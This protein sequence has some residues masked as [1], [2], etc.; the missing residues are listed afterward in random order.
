MAKGL[1]LIGCCGFMLNHPIF[2]SGVG[3]VDGGIHQMHVVAVVHIAEDEIRVSATFHRRQGDGTLDGD[4]ILT[5]VRIGEQ[6]ESHGAHHV[7]ASVG[8]PHTPVAVVGTVR[9]VLK[10]I[11]VGELLASSV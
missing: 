6:E 3:L 8:G 5:A 7:V 11:E 1:R 2:I 9:P 4:E 10:H